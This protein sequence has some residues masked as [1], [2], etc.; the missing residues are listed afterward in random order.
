MTE[1]LY[2]SVAFGSIPVIVSDRF[3]QVGAPFQN[4]VPYLRFAIQLNEAAVHRNVASELLKVLDRLS[5]RREQRMRELALAAQR[6]L[7]WSSPHSR[8]GE[9]VLLEAARVRRKLSAATLACF[10]EWPET[11]ALVL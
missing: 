5:A 2:Q 4:I 10:E 11:K 7:L 3:F 8:V 1:R 9:N 6:D